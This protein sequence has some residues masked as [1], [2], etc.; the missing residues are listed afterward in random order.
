MQ[1]LTRK[2]RRFEHDRR[3]KHI[4]LKEYLFFQGKRHKL[5]R[6]GDCSRIP[7]LDRYHPSLLIYTLVVLGLSLVDA[8]LTLT[9]LHRGAVE[10]NPTM[11]YYIGLGPQIFI[12]VK[13]G[14][15]A[16]ALMIMVVLHAAIS[17][18]YRILS[19]IMFPSCII[20]FAS[21]IVWEVYLLAQLSPL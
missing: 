1:E 12:V 10:L 15:T 21:V 18:K 16:I 6:Q 9:L 2:D 19:S 20:V 14:L 5:R 7:H 8:A 4:S 11:R 3:Q 17:V 13:Y